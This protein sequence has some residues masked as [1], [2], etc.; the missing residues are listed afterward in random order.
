MQK[1]LSNQAAFFGSVNRFQVATLN[2]SKICV[3]NLSTLSKLKFYWND[4][5]AAV[6]VTPLLCCFMLY[7]VSSVVDLQSLE[8]SQIGFW[9][10][11]SLISEVKTFEIRKKC[12]VFC[13]PCGALNFSIN[14]NGKQRRNILLDVLRLYCIHLFIFTICIY[15]W[16]C[17][18]CSFAFCTWEISRVLIISDTLD[19]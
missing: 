9:M 2:T 5:R 12:S 16:S 11:H 14:L 3:R 1:W 8:M 7:T 19:E 10:E 6:N 4:C 13:G 17:V 15:H 18:T